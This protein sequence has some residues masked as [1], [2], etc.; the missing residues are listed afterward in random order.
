MKKGFPLLLALVMPMLL[1]AQA[2]IAEYDK[3]VAERKYMTAWGWLEKQDPDNQKPEIFVLKANHVMEY[4]AVSIMHQMFG[5]K[6]LEPGEDLMQLRRDMNGTTAMVMLNIE[7]VTDSL[8]VK[9]PNNASLYRIKGQYH[10]ELYLKYGGNMGISEE[11]QLMLS[12]KYYNRSIEM[13][14]EDAFAY[15]AVGYVQL[16]DGDMKSA[17]GNFLKSIALDNTYGPAHYNLSYIYIQ[18]QDYKNAQEKAYAAALLY[19]DSTY[20]GDA[21]RVA[22]IAAKELKNYD[23]AVK[24]LNE[25]LKY[26]QHPA[27]YNH[28]INI[29]FAKKDKKALVEYSG[30]LILLEPTDQQSFEELLILY[31]DQGAIADLI[32][33]LQGQVK[34]YQNQPEALTLVY[35]YLSYANEEIKQDAEALKYLKLTL[36]TTKAFMEPDN[37]FVK[38]LEKEI[39]QRE[40]KKK[41]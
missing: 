21:Y 14:D 32:T 34:P 24:L 30:K 22:G 1:M 26:N 41:K 27:T 7:E 28:L 38:G 40:K 2:N 12:L 13:G 4:F 29:A 10:Y 33:F 35:L 36:E 18:Q 11:E 6:D 8:L 31:G 39:A 16:L 9:H 37:K 23:E 3:L 15:Y 5:L 25:S 20:K 17:A 19:E